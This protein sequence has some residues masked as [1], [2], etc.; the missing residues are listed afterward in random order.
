MNDYEK[1]IRVHAD[2]EAVHSALTT[3][4]G[5]SAWW[6]RA[7]GTG[8]AGGDLR[9]WFD[10]PEPLVMHVDQV[11]A[12]MVQWRVTDCAFLTEWV[13]TRPTFAITEIDRKPCEIHFRHHG[14]TPALEC[15]E[16]CTRGWNHF[17]PSLVQ[18]LE[19]GAG[20]PHGSPADLA[21]HAHQATE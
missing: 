9:F 16:M 11:T 7:T 21:R 12:S 20:N 13:G 19:T 14:L 18:Y 2:P 6:T 8:Q 10:R 3:T 5:L 1:T 4:A 17:I 15:I